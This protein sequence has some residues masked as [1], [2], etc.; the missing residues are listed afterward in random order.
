MLQI[1]FYS[2]GRVKMPYNVSRIGDG[3]RFSDKLQ[4]KK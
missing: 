2:F 3:R 1:R 4:T